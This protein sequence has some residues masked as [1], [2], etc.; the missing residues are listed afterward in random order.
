MPLSLLLAMAAAA[1]PTPPAR[2]CSLIWPVAPDLAAARRIAQAVIASRP[3]PRR[4]RYVLQ[5]IADRDDPGRWLA[6]QSLP[7]PRPSR[8]PWIVSVT[9]GGGGVVMRIDRCTGAIS[10]L[11]YAR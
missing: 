5:V 1:Q 11:H 4:R 6:M 9:A 2:A 8:H 7:E 10:Q 3:F